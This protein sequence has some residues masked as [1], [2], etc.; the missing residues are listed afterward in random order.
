[1]PGL[2][3]VQIIGNLGKDPETRYTPKGNSV[4]S[5]SVA[6]N[7]QWKSNGETKEATEWFN[8]ETWGK[9]G[10]L[11]QQYVSLGRWVFSEGRLH[12]DRYDPEGKTQYFTKVV[13]SQMHMLDRQSEEPEVGTLV[14]EDEETYN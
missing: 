5:F 14:A 8:I 10:E 2:N 12:T 9:L 11:C 3:R 1:M 7:R 4:C 13:A 6:V